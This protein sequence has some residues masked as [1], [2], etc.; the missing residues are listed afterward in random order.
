MEAQ[1]ISNLLQIKN[2][3]Q[4]MPEL[5]LP[6]IGESNRLGIALKSQLIKD[7][8]FEQIKEVLRLV[9]IKVGLR[10]HNFPNDIEKLVLFEHIVQNY[11]GNRL[12]EIRLAFDMAIMEK[13][14]DPDG[15]VVNPNSFENFSCAY[16]SKIMNGYRSWAAQEFRH[17]DKPEM[18]S[19]RIFTQDEL[20]ES[21]REDAERQY[22]MFTRGYE[23][24]NT[25]I[26][27]PIL[28]KDGLMREGETVIE[29]F[30]K[31]LKAGIPNIYIKK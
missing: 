14:A 10:G 8:T 12:D 28:K 22:V 16:F 26:N 25:L 7:S 15:E 24:K 18:P 31:R 1:H 30:T 23:I 20:D 21:A 17:V 13:L 3:E 29:F 9:M 4:A 19:Q 2:S 27:E 11:G 6:V 5:K